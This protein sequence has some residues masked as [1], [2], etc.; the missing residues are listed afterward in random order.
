M[1]RKKPDKQLRATLAITSSMSGLWLLGIV[2][3]ALAPSGG[4]FPY[5]E[6]LVNVGHQATSLGGLFG[7]VDFQWM[8]TWTGP[9]T[10]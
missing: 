4:G 8:F 7:T 3:L 6:G 2:A 10:L 1:F 9:T 5:A